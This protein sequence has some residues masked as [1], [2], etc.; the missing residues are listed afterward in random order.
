MPLYHQKA[1]E[2]KRE[3]CRCFAVVEKGRGWAKGGTGLPLLAAR[4]HDDVRRLTILHIHRLFTSRVIRSGPV[5]TQLLMHN[6]GIGSGV[7]A[8]PLGNPTGALWPSHSIMTQHPHMQS[9]HTCTH[10]CTH[11]HAHKRTHE[12]KRTESAASVSDLCDCSLLTS[13]TAD[14]CSHSLA[15]AGF[16]AALAAR[17]NGEDA[18]YTRK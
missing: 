3:S 12:Q 11:A 1:T 14:D 4:A 5:S 10:A 18:S 16:L 6:D 7:I 9:A 13:S 2:G 15:A 17:C 8:V